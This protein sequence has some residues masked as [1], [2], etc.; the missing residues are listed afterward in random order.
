MDSRG[1]CC[2]ARSAG[3]S[4]DMSKVDQIML[5]F[6]PIAPKPAA[7][8]VGYPP[9]RREAPSRCAKGKRKYGTR[10]STRLLGRKR[11]ATAVTLPLLPETPVMKHP[12]EDGFDITA[13]W[14]HKN[15]AAW[16]GS[17]YNNGARAI[18]AAPDRL[19]VMAPR[20][21]RV[22]GSCVTVERVTGA[23][24]DGE[25]LGMTDEER[26][27]NLE[28]DTCPG[29]VSDTWNRVSWT[30]GAYRRMVGEEEGGGS[31]VAVWVVMK[32]QEMAAWTHVAFTCRVRVQYTCGKGKERS[33]LTLPADVW[34]MDAG[35]YA[36]RLDV[37]AALRLGR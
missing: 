25:T 23:W 4:H 26:R 10:E 24:V 8:D 28:M 15:Q 29:F 19:A 7:D 6:R 17:D 1:G 35:G 2:I 12:P 11:K 13:A 9:E 5:Q 21:V 33:T 36:W 14:H 22:V 32:E 31:V 27:R 34:R 20:A 30:N 18:I 3:V 37:D 16:I